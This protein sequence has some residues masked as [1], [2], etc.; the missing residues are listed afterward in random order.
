MQPEKLG[1]VTD[2]CDWQIDEYLR[3]LPV[4][5]IILFIH[6]NYNHDNYNHADFVTRGIHMSRSWHEQLYSEDM[7]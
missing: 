1:N 4:S 7:K 3:Y 6:D 5:T 2:K